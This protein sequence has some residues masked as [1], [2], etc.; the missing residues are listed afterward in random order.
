MANFVNTFT[1]SNNIALSIPNKLNDNRNFVLIVYVFLTLNVGRYNAFQTKRMMSYNVL[2]A[3][4]TFVSLMLFKSV[5]SIAIL[6]YMHTFVILSSNL[7]S[8][9]L[10]CCCKYVYNN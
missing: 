1:C 2:S 4:N 6:D 3:I 8:C 5:H 7:L 10:F 9:N